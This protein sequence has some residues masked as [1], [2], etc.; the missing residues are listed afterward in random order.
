MIPPLLHKPTVGLTPTTP[1]RLEG[2]TIEPSVYVPMATAQK[3]ALTAAAEP[4]LDPE[5]LR[6][7]A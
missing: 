6:S 5:V 4:E 2:E 7:S 3:F 1:H